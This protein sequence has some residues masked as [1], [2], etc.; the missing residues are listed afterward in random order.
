LGFRFLELT[1]WKVS[2][3]FTDS[4]LKLECLG[5]REAI[6]NKKLLG[7][8]EAIAKVQWLIGYIVKIGEREC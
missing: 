6:A 5:F 1:K 3:R 2:Q 4:S 8:S 7:G